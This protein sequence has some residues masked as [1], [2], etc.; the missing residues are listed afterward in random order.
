[1]TLHLFAAD[2][3][4]VLP[5]PENLCAYGF[6]FMLAVTVVPAIVLILYLKGDRTLPEDEHSKSE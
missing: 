2:V 6:I 4:V 3:D 5:W 1:M